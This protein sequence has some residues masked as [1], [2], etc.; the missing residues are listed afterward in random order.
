MDKNSTHLKSFFAV[1]IL[2]LFG[3]TVS[4]QLT[5][6][7]TIPGDYNSIFD[8][9]TALNSQGVGSG[10][11]TFEIAAGYSE[12]SSLPAITASGSAGS[13]VVFQKSGTGSNPIIYAAS[14]SGTLDGIIRLEGAD[15]ITFDGLNLRDTSLNSSTAA[16]A[17]WGF[18]L[19]K[20]GPANGCQNITIKN[21]RINLTRTNTA[22]VGIYAANHTPA[23]STLITVSDPAGTNSYNQF[24]NNN[25]SN[26]YTGIRISGSTSSTY[27]DQQNKIG[28]MGGG[29][30]IANFGGGS[31]TAYGIYAIYQNN[32]EVG[33]NTVQGAGSTHTTTLYGIFLSTGT[34]SNA[35][36]FYNTVNLSTGSTSSTT[37][38][39]NNAMG[40][41][42]TNNQIN[43]YNNNVSNL[44]WP[45]VTSGAFYAVYNTASCFS[46]SMYNNSVSSNVKGG[47]GSFYAV[48]NSGSVVNKALMYGNTVSDNLSSSTGTFYGIYSNPGTSTNSDVYDNVVYRNTNGGTFYGLNST[49]GNVSNITNN[50]IYNN[51]TTGTTITGIYISSGTTVNVSRNKV[52]D[53]TSSG[54]SGVANGIHTNGGTTHNLSNNLIGD[55]KATNSSSTNAVIGLNLA[56][57]TTTNAYYNTIYLNATSTASTFGTSGIYATATPTVTLN[58]NL[59]VNL[60]TA[61]GSG[62]TVAHRRGTT[63]LADFVSSSNNNLYYAGTPSASNLIFYDGTTSF[64]TIADYKTYVAPAESASVTE[65]PVFLS[66]TGT[67]SGFLHIDPSESTA[68]ESGGQPVPGFI[69]DY[70]A[71]AVRT[72]Y[73]LAAQVNGGGTAP[74]IGADEGDF[75]P[76]TLDVSALSLIR[77]FLTGCPVSSDTV[78]VR[79]INNSPMSLD[80]SV[81]PVTITASVSG[82][83]PVTFSPVVINTGTL[84][85]GATMDIDV[86]TNYNM[87]AA[88]TYTFNA[89]TALSGDG[90]A[91]NDA[92]NAVTIEV[93]GGIAA[94]S[95]SSD[96][97]GSS[98]TLGVSGNSGPVQWQRF[99][100]TT[101]TWINETG[102]GS[103][104][105]SYIVTPADTTIYR[106][107]T[108]GSYPSVA[109]TINVIIANPAITTGDSNCGPGIVN[110]SATGAPLLNW[111]NST[112]SNT[113]VYTGSTYAPNLSAT[114]TYYVESLVPAGN[115]VRITEAD[116][117]T[118]DRIEIQNLSPDVVNTA[119]WVVAASNSYTNINSVNTIYWNLPATMQPGE[120]LFKTDQSSSPNY[121]GNNLFWNPGAF[122]SFAGWVMIV[123]NNGKVVDF[124]AW[125]WPASDIQGMSVTI[126]GFPVTIGSSWVGDGINVTTV[127]S[128]SSVSRIGNSESDSNADFAIEALTVGTQNSSLAYPWGCKASTRTA[129]TGTIHEIPVATASSNNIS[130]YGAADGSAT[131]NVSLG[132]VPYTYSW[133]TGGTLATETGLSAG[134][135]MVIVADANGC[136]DTVS[137]MITEPAA[138]I[139]SVSV[140][141]E[142]GSTGNGSSTATVTGGTSPYAY[143]WNTTP[144]QTTATAT[145]LSAG[146]YTVIVT[147]DNACA[148]TISV[149]LNSLMLPNIVAAFSDT[150]ICEGSSLILSATGANSYVWDNGAGNDDSVSVTPSAPADYIVTGTAANG[151][152]STDTVSVDFIPAPVASFTLSGSPAVTFTNMSVNANSYSWN[153]GDGSAAETTTSPS[154]TF[155]ADGTYNVTLVASNECTSDT[156][157]QQVVIIGTG[158]RSYASAEFVVAPNP[159]N[160]R[161]NISFKGSVEESVIR[162][163]DAQGKIVYHE[164]SKDASFE[165]QVDLSSHAKGVYYLHLTSGKN[166]YT[167]HLVIN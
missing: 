63:S 164:I 17:E 95:S 158:V 96:C 108:C 129:V 121:W 139:V 147:D 112:S 26:A 161:F 52:F 94:A 15:H 60:S 90:N 41:S 100:E 133:S 48:Y 59:V 45:T 157:I 40:S 21:C 67:S 32:L 54:A 135:Y 36:I 39:I 79:I 55:L 86:S 98:F 103:T 35:D 107:L 9:I 27:Y 31:S 23:S 120:V 143:A 138:L 69:D 125:G 116:L 145:G 159:S 11:V 83:N 66:T 155:T 154:H 72:G 89:S 104:S 167:R 126:N 144:A 152:S 78:S 146:T 76:V 14:G 47:S 102:T 131:A 137:A 46:I 84:A 166:T 37:Y 93:S 101:S 110:L 163:M 56:A 141:D 53:Q 153:F 142:C 162:I 97:Q 165:K 22:T 150:L 16:Q 81:N 105:S 7:K 13:P 38:A 91:T 28:S 87:T 99:D 128:T 117:G 20:A 68:V 115:K 43:I 65:N 6:T 51:S 42:G 61:A 74:D 5:G 3:N 134:T 57:G 88:G 106:A 34:N 75:S 123:D 80:F 25:I 132:T 118:N 124:A 109:D 18:A 119:G 30:F 149:T 114:T 1:S 73:P 160:G 111:Y 58:N 85:G 19:L 148:D 8:A 151:C 44:S 2:L 33:Y 10:G 127:P 140:T 50:T 122:P 136:S 92:M 62:L 70:D 4:A 29:N 64:Q 12:L 24:Q 71:Q 113:P 130:C 156:L 82:P 77:P 49:T